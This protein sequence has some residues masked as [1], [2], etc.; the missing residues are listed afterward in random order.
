MRTYALAWVVALALGCGGDGEEAVVAAPP[1]DRPEPTPYEPEVGPHGVEA[2][3]SA[4]QASELVPT[5]LELAR[6]IDP[7]TVRAVYESFV[8]HADMACPLTETIVSP[9]GQETTTLWYAY[10]P[11]TTADGTTFSGAGRLNVFA[12]ALAD[13][14]SEDGFGLS[15]EGSTMEIALAGGTTLRASLYLEASMTITATETIKSLYSFGHLVTDAAAATGNVWLEGK[16]RGTT[17]IYASATPDGSYVGLYGN[18][19]IVDEAMPAVAPVTAVSFNN[20]AVHDYGCLATLGAL[21]LRDATT[22]HEAVFT[23]GE[24]P[25]PEQACDACADLSYAGGALGDFCS[26]ST[27]VSELIAWGETPW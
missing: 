16:L 8:A 9:D 21:S 17:G 18:F 10:E 7:A 26:D 14:S 24:E 2:G 13:G 5:V 4:E 12:R 22:W 19:A 20:L 6:A 23:E 15:T 11:C 3:I 25:A 27:L 1:L